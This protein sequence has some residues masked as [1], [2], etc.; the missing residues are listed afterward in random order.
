MPSDLISL[1]LS[2]VQSR[3]GDPATAASVR[4]ESEEARTA[5]LS[6]VSGR[7]EQKL[8]GTLCV[9]GMT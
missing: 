8:Q 1:S 2:G 3:R 7:T 6:E 4:W 9:S 5:V